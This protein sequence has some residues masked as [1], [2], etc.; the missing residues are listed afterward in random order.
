MSKEISLQ[1]LAAMQ[2]DFAADPLN[3][4]RQRAVIKNGIAATAAN[5]GDTIANPMVF[6][7]E[8]ET[9]KITNQKSSGRCWLFAGLNTMRLEVMRRCNLDTFELSQNYAMFFDKLE[10]AN[11]FLEAILETLSEPT[12]SRLI[13]HLCAAPVQDGGQWD[14]FCA[15]VDKYG[16]VP[17]AFMPETFHSSN[18]GVMN[19]FLTLRLRED[20]MH[21]RKAFAQGQPIDA[22]RAQKDEML[23][24]IYRILCICLGNPPEQFVWEYRDKDKNF[25]RTDALTPKAFY[26]T[27][28]GRA[29]DDYISII[30]APTADKPYNRTYTV[31]FLG[32]VLGGRSVKY[33]NLTS[34]EQKAL[35][36]AQLSDNEPVWYGCDVGQMLER[37]VGLMGMHT[38]DYESVLGVPFGMDK[39]ERLDYY[40]SM[41]TH[42]MVLLGVNLVDGKPNRWKVEN[43]WGDKSGQD[44]YYIMSD[45]WFD[46]YNYQIVVHKKYLSPA[47]LAAWESEPIHLKPWDPMGSLA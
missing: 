28:V 9:G 34:E 12:D 21:L 16:V 27:Y 39:A 33:L 40:S 15:L 24:E 45:E 17:K 6:S 38:F 41:L 26:E 11:Y 19:K 14:M 20:A 2:Q 8:I 35:A 29:L 42:A 44:G 36:I 46:Q 18:T 47:Q 4:M 23:S 10:K 37:E 43:S 22:L 7:I 25:I 30:N 1:A 31:D 13:A 32:N 3:A 5:I